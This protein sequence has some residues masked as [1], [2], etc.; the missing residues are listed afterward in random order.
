MQG[1]TSDEATHGSSVDTVS[2]ISS[3]FNCGQKYFIR[4][5]VVQVVRKCTGY[6]FFVQ[7]GL[8]YYLLLLITVLLSSVASQ[9]SIWL[10]LHKCPLDKAVF[11]R[12]KVNEY[13]I[14]LVCGLPDQY[15]TALKAVSPAVAKWQA[16][17]GQG[18]NSVFST[19]HLA[20]TGDLTFW[21]PIVLCS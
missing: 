14:L 18:Q 17:L 6:R 16:T 1:T 11:V 13:C 2:S 4:S 15:E 10:L 21:L 5:V 8:L 9:L 20:A 3:M 12:V 19:C 7:R